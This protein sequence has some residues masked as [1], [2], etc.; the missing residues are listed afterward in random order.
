MLARAALGGVAPPSR[1][2][3]RRAPTDRVA[4]PVCG[5]L[6]AL[7][8]LA[9]GTLAGATARRACPAS[10]PDGASV[11]LAGSVLDRIPAEARPTRRGRRP[12]SGRATARVGS[13]T[14]VAGGR[15]CSPG[16]LRVTLEREARPID[17]G[18]PVLAYG[19][20]RVYGTPGGARPP[21]RQGYVSIGRVVRI[22]GDSSVAWGAPGASPPPRRFGRGVPIRGASLAARLRGRLDRRLDE[23]LPE[24]EAA[25]ARALVL[26]EATTLSRDTRQAFVDA[27]IVHLLAISGLHVGLLAASLTWFLGLWDRRPRRWLTAAALVSA[28]VALI[29][30]PPA[31]VRAALLFW[32]HALTRWRGRPARLSDLAGLAALVVLAVRPLT[33]ADPGFQLSFAGFGGVVVGH[34][35]GLRL[36][37]GALVA[38]RRG[39]GLLAPL[40]ASAGAFV[41]TAPIAALHFGRVVAT[42]I[43]ASLVAT[44]LVGLAIPAVFATAVLPGPPGAA[45]APAAALLLH[46]LA[47]LARGFA[48]LPLRW[49]VA[50]PESWVW[51][52]VGALA[53]AAIKARRPLRWR[54]GLAAGLAVAAWIGR[55]GLRAAAGRGHPLLCTL[56]VGQGDAAVVRTRSGRWLLFD[57][58]PGTSILGDQPLEGGPPPDPRV[59]DA[60][61][62]VI[63]PFLR[64]RGARR[65][66]L[67]GLS[68]PHLDH[69]GGTGAVFDA[70]D[71]A[72][73]VDPGV[74]EPSP[75]YRAFLAR[76]AEEG[77]V[78]IRAAA[79]GDLR[80]DD[81]AVHI[82]WPPV[83]GPGEKMELDANEGSFA[84]LLDAGSFRYLNTGDAPSDVE[85]AILS[86]VR[87]DSLRADILKLGHHGSRTSGAV[88]W[89][90][91][92]HPAIAVISAGRGNRYGHP[93]A[94]TLA[95]LDSAHIAR[96]WRTDLDGPLCV[97]GAAGA[98]RVVDP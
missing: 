77:A 83:L 62:R 91:T 14:L 27:G 90:R 85:R 89:L 31:A 71:V 64:A 94:A 55:P 98:W 19:R 1:P 95:R 33:L 81:I 88:E 28:Y 73:V 4:W 13:V 52:G 25:I 43:P 26:A 17:V 7:A 66:E 5:A 41:A 82:L 59:G 53:T 72:R 67:L 44:G 63:V 15:V 20:W 18:T 21:D 42:S 87:A 22:E 65:I 49:R 29:G 78:W 74:V 57:G 54:Y 39:C 35:L 37:G 8:G 61:R 9:A 12:A 30:A 50:A 80:I 70:F 60:G 86:R 47:A 46:G 23:R 45:I 10:V 11:A 92:V 48:S 68:H 38:H 36:T 16:R 69:F 76:S 51:V 96:V 24:P 34:R 93:H 6:L 58:G 84:F 97:E 56:D 75:P 40:A 2:A 79:G 3:A 32:G